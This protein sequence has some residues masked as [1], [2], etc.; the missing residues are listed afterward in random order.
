[1]LLVVLTGCRIFIHYLKFLRSGNFLVPI[2]FGLSIVWGIFILDQY[3][4]SITRNPSYFLMI[5]M[6]LGLTHAVANSMHEPKKSNELLQPES[7]GGASDI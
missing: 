1:M 5:W 2:A 4:I 6:L 7:K 3:K